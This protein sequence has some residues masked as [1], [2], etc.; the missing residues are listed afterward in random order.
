MTQLKMLMAQPLLYGCLIKNGKCLFYLPDC[1]RMAS[2]KKAISVLWVLK[3]HE[4][5]ETMQS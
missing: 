2:G 5:V 3:V 4:A 1:C